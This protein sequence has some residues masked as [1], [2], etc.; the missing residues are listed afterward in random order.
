MSQPSERKRWFLVFENT[1]CANQVS[2]IIA[3]LT[4]AHQLQ[5]R[6]LQQ[7]VQKIVRINDIGDRGDDY[8]FACEICIDD[9][10]AKER[11]VLD[12]CLACTVTHRVRTFVAYKQG[13]SSTREW[14]SAGGV[15]LLGE[16][17]L[18]YDGLQ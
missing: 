12:L 1:L 4:M 6:E 8:I 2:G 7:R 13:A 17:K 14:Q 16:E 3:A 9:D 5:D 10:N 11:L 18:G 15:S